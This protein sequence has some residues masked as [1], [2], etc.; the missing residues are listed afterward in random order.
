MDW[1][2]QE[3]EEAILEAQRRA[4]KIESATRNRGVTALLRQMYIG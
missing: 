3:E 2:D 1:A 4:A